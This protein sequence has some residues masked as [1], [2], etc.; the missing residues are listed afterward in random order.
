M[1]VY[2][3]PAAEERSERVCACGCG[4]SLEGRQRN[5]RYATSTCRSKTSKAK[6]R[7]RRKPSGPQLSYHKAVARLAEYLA[8]QR[9]WPRETVVSEV[10]RENA[11]ALLRPLLPDRQKLRLR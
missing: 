7:P 11:E 8:D 10:D 6:P 4:A 9:C 1:T 2:A 5:T 3:L